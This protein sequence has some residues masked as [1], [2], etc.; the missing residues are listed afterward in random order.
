V[1]RYP[2]DDGLVLLA[3]LG[4]A[5]IHDPSPMPLTIPWTDIEPPRQQRL[6]VQHFWSRRGE[7]RPERW[8]L[9]F[10]VVLDDAVGLGAPRAESRAF[11]D[12]SSSLAVSRR[13]GYRE[14]GREVVARRGEKATLVRVVLEEADWTPNRRDNI[15]IN[16]LDRC[17]PPF[18]LAP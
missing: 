5:G 7:W 10:A 18:K 11:T 4:A 6:S 3:D 2:D 8:W 17:L 16:G 9:P 15:E 14:T 1:R 12:N 13:L